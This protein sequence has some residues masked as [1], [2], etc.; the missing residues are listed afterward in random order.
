[1]QIPETGYTLR[2]PKAPKFS[3]ALSGISE[4]N[5]DKPATAVMFALSPDPNNRQ[6]RME[7]PF[8]PSIS[9]VPHLNS[10]S[11]I[12]LPHSISSFEFRFR[13]RFQFRFS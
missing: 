9:S 12:Q 7:L 4:P 8:G 2:S 1:M 3:L 10:S 11:P 6:I 5:L 13:F